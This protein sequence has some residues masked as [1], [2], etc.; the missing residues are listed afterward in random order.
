[1]STLNSEDSSEETSGSQSK[2]ILYFR[3][4]FTV[5]GYFR[6]REIVYSQRFEASAKVG[7][8]KWGWE[9]PANIIF[10]L[11]YKETK[12]MKQ[13]VDNNNVDLRAST[14]SQ[15][16]CDGILLLLLMVNLTSWCNIH[17]QRPLI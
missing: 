3:D 7:D 5:K 17:G 11:L 10:K 16:C 13:T 6:F 4:W 1:M 15:M 14:A 2:Y 12:Q 8:W 9:V